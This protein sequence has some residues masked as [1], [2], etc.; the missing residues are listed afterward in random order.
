LGNESGREVLA[1]SHYTTAG[2]RDF[3][4]VELTIRRIA[5]GRAWSIPLSAPRKGV[6]K[7]A[8]LLAPGATLRHEIDLRPWAGPHG[9]TLESGTFEMTAVYRVDD[10]EPAIREWA[11]CD[12]VAS[13]A[14]AEPSLVQGPPRAPWRGVLRSAAVIVRIAAD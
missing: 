11:N 6:A 5:D 9:L 4:Q 1:L 7:V 2:R 12:A 3:D 10:G 13:T 14:G 8:C